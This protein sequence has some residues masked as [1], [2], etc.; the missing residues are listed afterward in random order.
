MRDATGHRQNRGPG[1]PKWFSMGALTKGSH[2]RMTGPPKLH[3]S[4]S[5]HF[6]RV[7]AKGGI[8]RREN[9]SPPQGQNEEE[10]Q[11][12]KSPLNP[13]QGTHAPCLAF[14][15]GCCSLPSGLAGFLYGIQDQLNW[16]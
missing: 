14:T 16:S 3:L 8:G 13:A 2:A 1:F 9:S 4:S 15:V 10:N 7:S 12:V 6:E 5:A 11:T